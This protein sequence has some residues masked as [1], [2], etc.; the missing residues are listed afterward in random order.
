MAAWITADPEFAQ[1]AEHLR[2][3]FGKDDLMESMQAKLAPSY[4]KDQPM[5]LNIDGVVMD[6][7]HMAHFRTCR[8]FSPSEE[9]SDF[10]VSIE[11]FCALPKCPFCIP[12]KYEGLG[13]TISSE[14]VS[15]LRT[16]YIQFES[17]MR[18][19]SMEMAFYRQELQTLR[20]EVKNEVRT[21]K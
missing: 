21:K 4:V 19:A 2:G 8:Y 7:T 12:A 1:R 10:R 5:A 20:D 3:L 6:K 15:V 9:G 17:F 18:V 16:S 14:R 13:L 11:E